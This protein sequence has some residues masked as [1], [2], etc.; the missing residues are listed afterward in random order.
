MYAAR[1]NPFV[2]FHSIIDSRPASRTT[3]TSPTSRRD[4]AVE[5]DDAELLVHRPRTSAT[6]ATTSRARTASPA[7]STQ[8][9]R[10][11]RDHVPQILASPAYKD[12]GLLIV[13]FDEAE[14]EAARATTRAR[15]ATSSRAP[16]PQPRAAIVGPGRRADRRRAAVAVHQAGDG[17]RRPPTTTTRCCAASRTCS[18]STTSATPARRGSSRSARAACSSRPVRGDRPDAQAAQGRGRREDALPLPGQLGRRRV[19]ARRRD[20]LRRQARV[21]RRRRQGQDPHDTEVA[22]PLQGPRDQGR[23][24]SR[25]RQDQG[26]QLTQERLQG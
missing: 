4:L 6:T 13:T 19:R 24:R 16:T 10:W 25:Q 18:G 7:A 3:S 5:A 23:L 21:H 8:A 1:H 11:L 12:H 26:P 9:D 2:Y 20:P 15:A 17:R 14:A 22:A